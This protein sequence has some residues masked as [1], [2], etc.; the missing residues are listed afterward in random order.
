VEQALATEQADAGA[1]DAKKLQAA[2]G[3][4]DEITKPL[5]ELVMDRAMEALLRK[6]GVLS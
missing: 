5:A 2:C 1:G 4:L 3:E 6:K